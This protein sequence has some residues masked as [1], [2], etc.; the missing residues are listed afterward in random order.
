MITDLTW[1]TLGGEEVTGW[2]N[3]QNLVGWLPGKKEDYISEGQSVLIPVD[4]D[5]TEYTFK[6]VMIKFDK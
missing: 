6:T 2:Y 4:S 5:D 3:T 1:K